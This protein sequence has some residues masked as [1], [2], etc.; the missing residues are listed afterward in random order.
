MTATRDEIL[1]LLEANKG[2]ITDN[3]DEFFAR[4]A[5][6]LIAVGVDARELA[7]ALVHL[8]VYHLISLNGFSFR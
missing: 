2:N 4:N 3:L 1:K 6:D 5:E 8:G 7:S